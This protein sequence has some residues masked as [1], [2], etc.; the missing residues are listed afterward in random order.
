MESFFASDPW[1]RL[2]LYAIVGIVAEI[3]FTALQDLIDPRFLKSWNVHGRNILQE[4]PDWRWQG[5]DPRATGYTFLWMIPIYMAMVFLEPIHH[6][7]AHWP[8]PLRGLLYVL[9]VWIAEYV[10]GAI[11]RLVTGKCPW[12]YSYSKYS[13][14]GLIRWDF[15]H[16]WFI[17]GFIFEYLHPRLVALTPHIRAIF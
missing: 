5:R 8:W 14:H 17:F 13:L 9:L 2:P 15:A 7:I 12:D 6:A 16:V 10:T 1:V 11:I 3:L 4:R